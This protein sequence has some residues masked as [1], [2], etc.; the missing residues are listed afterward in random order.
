MQVFSVFKL[1]NGGDIYNLLCIC[2]TQEKALEVIKTAALN[3]LNS[4]LKFYIEELHST[5]SNPLDDY[6]FC[7]AYKQL[8]D[9]L[10][11]TDSKLQEFFNSYFWVSCQIDETFDIKH[12]KHFQGPFELSKE[13]KEEIELVLQNKLY[14]GRFEQIQIKKVEEQQYPNTRK[15]KTVQ[16]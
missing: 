1:L 15:F 16:M 13:Q 14:R 7:E 11:E 5:V 3:D 6:L 12:K 9:I 2:S 10:Y 8:R 4:S